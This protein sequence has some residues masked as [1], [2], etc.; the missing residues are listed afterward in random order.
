MDH[1]PAEHRTLFDFIAR[2]LAPRVSPVDPHVASDTSPLP[3]ILLTE[4]NSLLDVSVDRRDTLQV[5]EL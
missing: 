2:R 1:P 4:I 5:H 3:A